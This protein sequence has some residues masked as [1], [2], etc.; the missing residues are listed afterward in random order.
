MKNNNHISNLV[1]VFL[2]ALTGGFVGSG[3]VFYLTDKPLESAVAVESRSVFVEES[4]TIDSIKKVNPSVVSIIASKQ[5]AMLRRP[6]SLFDLF[7]PEFGFRAPGVIEQ[8]LP[9][10][11]KQK[12]GGGSG[13]IITKDGLVLT[14]KH[15]INDDQ[16]EYSVVLPDGT[17]YFAKVLSKDPLNDIAFVQLFE[18]SDFEKN[19]VICQ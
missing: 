12:V 17:E 10:G 9:S 3:S 15:V 2:V 14:N 16:A 19:R 13:F 18:D 6:T 1:I 7:A 11:E 5:L 8:E 4:M